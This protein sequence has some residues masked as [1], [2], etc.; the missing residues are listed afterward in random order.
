M[1]VAMVHSFYDS[2]HPSGENSQVSAEF[3][4]LRS[5]GYDVRLFALHTDDVQA[6]VLYRVRSGLR[7]A[8]GFGHSPLRAID[9]FAPDVVHIHNLFPNFGRRW[10]RRLRVPI[11]A[12]VHNFRFVCAGGSLFREGRLCTDCLDG[13]RWAGVRHRC[14]RDSLAATLPL[15]ISQSRG[16][17]ADPALAS[18]ARILCL[19]ARQRRALADRGVP[20]ERLVDWANFLPHRYDPGPLRP[21][22]DR[23]RDGCLFVGRLSPEKGPLDLVRAWRGDMTLRVVGDGPQ[24]AEVRREADRR[25][26]VEMLGPLPRSSVVDLMT[27]SAVLAM[28]SGGPEGLPLAYLEAVASGLPVAVSRACDVS[29]VVERDR[30]GVVVDTVE[31]IPAAAAAAT[32]PALPGRCRAAYEATYTEEAWLARVSALYSSLAGGEAPHAATAAG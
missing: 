30:S 32:D 19:S 17:A 26:N 4:L 20:A 13:D 31:E 29:H 11:V 28:P 3:E 5:A 25:S 7:V 9:A 23:P 14:Y 24:R 16:P 18:A 15:A 10:I 8:T 6:E 22:G 21:R 2:A 1:R 27:T 12:T